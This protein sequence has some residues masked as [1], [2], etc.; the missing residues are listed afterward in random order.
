MQQNSLA[1]VES[2]VGYD[3]SAAHANFLVFIPALTLFCL[4]ALSDIRVP[5]VYMDAVNPDYM[6]VRLL[7]PNAHFQPWILPGALVLGLFPLLVQVY[8]G[9]LP[10]YVGLPVYALLGTGV[11]GIRVANMVFGLLV[12]FAAGAFMR[13]FQVRASIAALCLAALALDPGFLFSFRTQF[14]ILLLPSA[15]LFTSVALT[16]RRRRM[17]TW[18]TAATAGL[19]AGLACYGYFIYL[20]AVP[21]VAAH[22]WLR[23][24]ERAERYRLAAW[25][26]AGFA[27]AMAPYPASMLL[28]LVATGGLHGFVGFWTAYL[29]TLAANKSQLTMMS[30][31]NFFFNSVRRTVL[32]TGPSIMML[33]KPLPLSVPT[34]KM[35]LLLGVPGIGL[36]VSLI[37]A[38]RFSGLV[39]L[40][41]FVLGEAVLFGVFGDRLWLQHLVV[42][43]PI[44][45]IAFA[46]TLENAAI[47]L[48]LR[49]SLVVDIAACVVMT[50]LVV[51]NVVDSQAML[52][53]L[54]ETGGVGFASDAL[55]HFAD[56][57]LLNRPSATDAFFPDWG[58][59][60][61]FVMITHGQIA[62]TTS[63]SPDEARRALCNGHDVLLALM[64]NQD[65]ERLPAW[66]SAIDRG[67]PSIA[68]YRQHDGTPVLIAIRWHASTQS[69]A[70][71]SDHPCQH[72]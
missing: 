18:G 62:T 28:T 14:Y 49:R 54:R 6:V 32:D 60:M 23:W 26:I 50:P 42:L 7:Y 45:Y 17:P 16:E 35:W 56:D 31:I 58:I 64:A 41:A 13:A 65:P 39:V 24:R 51:G 47:R 21:S 66:I 33:H 4:G 59:F 67:Q 3:R 22:A 53:A 63:F 69:Q 36:V 72:P 27:L 11:I 70:L 38:P 44:L 2:I 55:T 9:A 61:S 15:A 12:I 37:R 40:G 71:P 8:H 68:T 19:L 1:D 46:L 5:G 34:L 10:F 20:F 48:A 52:Q 25:W 43:L 30:R 29:H 57:S